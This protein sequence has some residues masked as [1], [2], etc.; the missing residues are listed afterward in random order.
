M[1]DTAVPETMHL[2]TEVHGA[3]GV[4]AYRIAPTQVDIGD[5]AKL[6][7]WSELPARGR[8][9]GD[10]PGRGYVRGRSV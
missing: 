1:A 6:T 7:P 2:R 4:L 10:C 5:E 9:S 8:W 3:A